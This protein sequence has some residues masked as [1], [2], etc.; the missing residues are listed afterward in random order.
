MNKASI[1]LIVAAAM[2]LMACSENLPTTWSRNCSTRLN[3]RK[4][5]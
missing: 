5:F 4:R 2:S 1:F 3:T